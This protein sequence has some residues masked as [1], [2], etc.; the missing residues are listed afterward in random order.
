MTQFTNTTDERRKK[1]LDRYNSQIAWYE[2]MKQNARV[3]FYVFQTLVIVFSGVTPV[4]ILTTDSK[5][6]Q[7]IFPAAASILAGLLGTYQFQGSW[8][9]RALALE[10]LRSE[11]VKFDTRSGADYGDSVTEDQAIERF[12]LEMENIVADEVT[13]W[14]RRR[15][16]TGK[17]NTT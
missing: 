13:E 12:V 7:A 14:Q 15:G 4:L 9:R 8:R 17:A 3:R 16:Q 1:A 6:V 11:F 2:K 10:T 5:L